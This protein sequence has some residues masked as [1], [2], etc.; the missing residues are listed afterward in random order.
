MKFSIFL[1]L[2]ALAF[3]I[4]IG[5]NAQ[6]LTE[7][8]AAGFGPQDDIQPEITA[9]AKSHF[10]AAKRAA[11][12]DLIGPLQLCNDA[13]PVGTKWDL[14][15]ADI[16]RG[17]GPTNAELWRMKKTLAEF[18][19]GGGNYR[20]APAP[21]RMFDN[22]YYVGVENVSAWAVDTSEGIILIDT[23]NNKGD[24]IERIEPGMQRIGLDPARIKY[25][26]LTHGHGDHF[27]GAAYLKDKYGARVL[28]SKVD[29]DL[30][31]GMLDKPYF[32][33]P[34][35]QDLMIEDG[36][37]LTLGGQT[38]RMYLTPGHTRGT[39]SLLIPVTDGGKK[40]V[41]ALWGGTGFNFPHTPD[42]FKTYSD[43]AIR[44]RKYAAAARADVILSPH[45]DF[46]GTIRK[47]ADLQSPKK[48]APHPFVL[49][50]DG[51]RRYLTIPNECALAYSAQLRTR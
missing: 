47:L 19:A 37:L 30:A 25:I 17:A 4:G 16:L 51:V 5:V 12:R 41:I 35:A 38:I 28:M 9:K 26:V 10:D 7:E 13:R 1:A 3:P 45:A 24:W 8:Q 21:T 15:K 31:P 14:P 11:R 29:W 27:G 20:P 48:G 39:A 46:D 40:H 44:F 42:R 6:Q 23:L 18:I 33:A 50:K 22:F 2:G 36:Q 32:G 43:S 34:P 49:G